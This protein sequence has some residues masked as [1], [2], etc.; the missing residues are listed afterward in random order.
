MRLLAVADDQ[1]L[2]ATLGLVFGEHVLDVEYDPDG[3]VSAARLGDYDAIILDEQLPGASAAVLIRDLKRGA[4]YTPTLC[5]MNTAGI[6][7]KLDCFA[8]G[9]D[10][11]VLKPF[12][13]DEMVARVEALARRCRSVGSPLVTI[14][15][16]Q[17]NLRARMAS[18]DGRQLSLTNKEYRLLEA[19]VLTRTRGPVPSGRLLDMLYDGCA[20]QPEVK[21]VDV[22]ICKIRR[23]LRE[24]GLDGYIETVWGRGYHLVDVEANGA[25]S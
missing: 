19:L 24:A 17:V 11:C 23:K 5:L 6:Q 7:P 20:D 1:S 25:A 22:F 14:G 13:K 21:I 8:A 2:T 16:L 3:V 12:H 4:V 18:A 9:A 15:R 10:D